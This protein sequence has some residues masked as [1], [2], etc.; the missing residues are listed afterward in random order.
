MQPPGKEHQT[1][2]DRNRLRKEVPEGKRMPYVT[3]AGS[4]KGEADNR[5]GK[6]VRKGTTWDLRG[7]GPALTTRREKWEG[8]PY[9]RGKIFIVFVRRKRF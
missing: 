6:L 5:A 3:E 8:F 2:E 9:R 1:T 7:C 4:R